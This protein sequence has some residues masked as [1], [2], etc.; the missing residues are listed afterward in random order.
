MALGMVE[1]KVEDGGE[2]ILHYVFPNISD[3]SEMLAFLKEFFPGGTFI[4][5]PVRH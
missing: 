2:A 1:M 3:A 5:Q 4:I